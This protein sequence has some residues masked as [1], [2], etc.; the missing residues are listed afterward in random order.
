MCG[1]PSRLCGSQRLWGG[2]VGRGCLLPGGNFV[3]AFQS[4]GGLRGGGSLRS[5]GKVKRRN[6][7]EQKGHEVQIRFEHEPP[8]SLMFISA[9]VISLRPRAGAH[10]TF[11]K[12]NSVSCWE[13]AFALQRRGPLASWPDGCDSSG[14]ATI[15]LS[16]ITWHGTWNL[17]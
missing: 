15:S 2:G 8:L 6:K 3:L 13:S 7:D 11:S 10:G 5:R 14:L 9:D 1:L 16:V 12:A 17:S 4:L